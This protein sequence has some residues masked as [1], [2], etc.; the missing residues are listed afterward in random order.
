MGNLTNTC[1]IIMILH[2]VIIIFPVCRQGMIF[3]LFWAS[4]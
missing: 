4:N 2:A 1:V 3:S